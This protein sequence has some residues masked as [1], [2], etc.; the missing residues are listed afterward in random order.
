MDLGPTKFS[1]AWVCRLKRQTICVAPG[2]QPK[3]LKHAKM[4]AFGSIS[5]SLTGV[6]DSSWPFMKTGLRGVKIT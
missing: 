6:P 4:S 3:R 1:I 2:Q 5:P